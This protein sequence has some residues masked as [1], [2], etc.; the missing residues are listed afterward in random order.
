MATECYPIATLP[1]ITRL[2]RDYLA[3]GDSAASLNCNSAR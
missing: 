2:Y 1:H 3:M